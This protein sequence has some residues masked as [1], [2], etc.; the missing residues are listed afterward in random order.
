[1]ER[2]DF[3]RLSATAAGGLSLAVSVAACRNDGE[4]PSSG[5]LFA[6]DA[7]IRIGGDGTV[8]VVLARSE[9]GQGVSTGL[10]M[11]VAEELEADWEALKVEQAPAHEAYGNS[12]LQA[13]VMMTGGSSS[14]R[15]AWEPLR[16]AGATARTLLIA[17]AAAEWGVPASECRAERGSVLHTRSERRAGFGDLA[18]AAARLPIPRDVALKPASEWRLIGR[19]LPRRDNADVV[20]GRATFG[21]DVR[22]PGMLYAS[23]ERAPVWGGKV[24]T[25]DAAAALA[26]PGVRHVFDLDDRVAV[27]ADRHWQ[28][29]QARRKLVIT[30]DDGPLATLTDATIGD[31]MRELADADEGG[32]AR[33]EGD[34]PAVLATGRVLEAEY[35]VPFLAHA[36]MEPMNCTV[37]PRSGE[38]WGPTQFQDGPA[39]IDGGGARGRLAS[40]LGRGPNHAKV[41]TTR[42]GGGFG[43]RLELD[44]VIEATEI[45]RRAGVPVQVI[46]TRED[47]VRHDRFRPRALH[48]L[49]ASVDDSGRLVAWQQQ[50][51]APSI[52]RKFVPRIVPDLLV[53][54]GGPL[55]R[56]VDQST[57]EGAADSPYHIPNFRVTSLMAN[58]GVPVGY[59][60]SVGHSHTAFAVECFVDELAR[61]AG[62]DPVEFRRQ[63]LSH[64]PRYR[65]VLD[66]AA[67]QAGWGT[68]LPAGRARGVAFHESFGS[69]VAEVAEVSIE[70]GKVRV[71]RVVC[72]ADCG[73]VVHP[74]LV[75]AQLEGAILFGLSAALFGEVNVEG[76]RVKQSNFHDY[77]VARMS[78]SPR[79]DVYLLPSTDVPGGVGEIGT[80][81]IAPAIANAVFALTGVPVR[82]LP[83]R[84]GG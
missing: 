41:H 61:K 84:V 37:D 68:P 57:V 18:A 11:L 42:L 75:H 34:A 63:L 1:M 40:G 13:G 23:V 36:T 44:Y 52:S 53:K 76:G 14:V 6:P 19:S 77:Q 33:N 3:L 50:I 12:A 66:L 73:M 82:R 79:I 60:R 17:A 80:P 24:R 65:A 8:T 9:M 10:P 28:A 32:V 54:L 74:D 70:G 31:R 27:V 30:W 58:V 67:E 47:D 59:W 20:A 64:L 72:A 38:M 69:R 62:A 25:L 7:W 83:I 56:G 35:E 2:R 29:L 48:R 81:P 55:K 45:A 22:L 21:L 43:R 71:H 26:A 78:D 5:A 49:K 16:R 51:V 4:A 46:W 15:E 39:M